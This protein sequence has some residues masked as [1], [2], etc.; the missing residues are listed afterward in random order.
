MRNYYTTINSLAGVTSAATKGIQIC[1]SLS[2]NESHQIKE[3]SGSY[4][5]RQKD[6][7]REAL[8]R[9]T[10]N[11]THNFKGRRKGSTDSGAGQSY[12]NNVL[13][14]VSSSAARPHHIIESA[15]SGLA[16]RAIGKWLLLPTPKKVPGYIL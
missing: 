4:F 14:T 10:K 16:M 9:N 7:K 15:D 5:R 3:S 13:G 6:L 2:P 12:W 11:T 8:R 1:P